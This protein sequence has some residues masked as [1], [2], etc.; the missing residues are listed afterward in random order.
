MAKSSKKE[1][2]EEVVVEIKEEEKEIS[3]LSKK[4]IYQKDILN[5]YIDEQG[6]VIVQDVERTTYK[7]PLSEYLSLRQ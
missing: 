5:Q 4:T 2:V 6:F 7:L 3:P 1:I